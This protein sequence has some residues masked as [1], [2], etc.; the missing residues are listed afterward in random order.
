[1]RVD[2][3]SNIEGIYEANMKKNATV[4]DNHTKQDNKLNQDRVEIS[5]NASNYDELSSLKAKIVKEVD[6]PTSPE[7]LRQLKAKIESGSY[8]VKS[9]DIA[10]AICRLSRK[11]GSED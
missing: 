10:G 8:Q 9:Q 1:M 6:A 7:K 11:D 4:S 5:E 3:K 2:P